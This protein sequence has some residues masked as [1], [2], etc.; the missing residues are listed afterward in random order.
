MGIDIKFPI[1][2][3]F[4]ILGFLLAIFGLITGGDEAL[5]SRSLGININ[6]WSGC[7][8]LAFGLIMLYLAWRNRKTKT[9]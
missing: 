7:G 5:Y 4:T 2:L 3:M 1:G 9:S 6:L 8:M